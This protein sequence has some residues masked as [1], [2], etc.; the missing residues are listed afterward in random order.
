LFATVDDRTGI[1]VPGEDRDDLCGQLDQQGCGG[2]ALGKL[3]SSP[4]PH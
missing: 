2:R 1:G 3:S 4:G